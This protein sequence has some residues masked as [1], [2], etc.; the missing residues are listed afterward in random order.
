MVR[1]V[2]PRHSPQ[3]PGSMD[4]SRSAEREGLALQRN[5][6]TA[7]DYR[8][9]TF[10][11]D[12]PLLSR[13]QWLMV[14]AGGIGSMTLPSICRADPGKTPALRPRRIISLDRAPTETLL[15]LGIPPIGVADVS[16]YRQWV[17]SPSLP[18]GTTDVGLPSAPNLEL[19]QQLKPELILVTQGFSYDQATLE[20]V[21]PVFSCVIYTQGDHPY[22]QARRVTLALGK[23]LAAEDRAEGLLSAAEEAMRRAQAALQPYENRPFY[24]V[25]FVDERHVFVFGQKSLFGDVLTSVGLRNAWT[26]PVNFWGYAVLG[27][28]ALAQ[29]PEAMLLIVGKTTDGVHRSLA[30]NSLWKNLPFVRDQHVIWMPPAWMFGAVPSAQRFAELLVTTLS[31]EPAHD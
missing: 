20:Q 30:A 28:D 22:R 18:Q 2:L 14:L 5:R 7:P 4:P 31:A 13:R 17:G 9:V 27:V 6:H 10:Q 21:A 25:S 23:T 1:R 3:L 16:G 11:D 29:T 15:A 8:S 26:G 19:L 24:V 12:R